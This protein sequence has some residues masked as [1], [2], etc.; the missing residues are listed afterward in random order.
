MSQTTVPG[1]EVLGRLFQNRSVLRA[2]CSSCYLLNVYMCRLKKMTFLYLSLKFLLGDEDSIRYL[3]ISNC[4]IYPEF[5]LHVIP[6][7]IQIIQ[8]FNLSMI[9]V[10]HDSS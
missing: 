7:E 1:L 5:S 4:F 6:T 10:T 8:N 9:Q 3:E 2:S